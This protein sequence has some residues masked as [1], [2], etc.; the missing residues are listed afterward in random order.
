MLSS[1]DCNPQVLELY[2]DSLQEIM[3][4]P[5]GIPPEEVGVSVEEYNEMCVV[6]YQIQ[7]DHQTQVTAVGFDLILHEE[8]VQH[9][10]ICDAMGFECT[11]GVTSK[12][13]QI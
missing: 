6:N 10:V 7:G 4:T 11:E 9:E 5:L 1:D 2:S 8:I 3:A 12:S 13:K